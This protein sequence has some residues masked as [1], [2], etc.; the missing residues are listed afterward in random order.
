VQGRHCDPPRRRSNKAQGFLLGQ[1]FA[2]LVTGP[3]QEALKNNKPLNI[4]PPKR[5]FFIHDY[6]RFTG[7]AAL[8]NPVRIAWL[9]VF[10]IRFLLAGKEGDSFGQIRICSLSLS[11]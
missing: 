1:S 7:G 10:I 6:E 9:Y 4:N 8:K 2:F 5:S 3:G 11:Q